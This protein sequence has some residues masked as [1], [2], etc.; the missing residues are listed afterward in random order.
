MELRALKDKD[1]RLLTVAEQT[2]MEELSEAQPRQTF[3]YIN[4]NMLTITLAIIVLLYAV[5]GGLEAAFITDMIQ[6]IFIIILTLMLI[7]FA[8][9][10]INWSL[11]H[12]RLSGNVPGA[13]RNLPEAFFQV[14]GSPNLPQFT[15]YYIAAFA[16]MAFLNTAV[17]ANQLT[18]A[19]SAKDDETA[20]IGFITG[21]FIKRYCGVIWGFIAM[22][23]L[24]LY[25]SQV[26][27]PDYVWGLATRELLPVGLVGLMIACSDGGPD[28]YGGRADADQLV[29]ADQQCL[30]A[31]VS[32]QERQP[33]C[34]GRPYFLPGL[35]RRRCRHCRRARR[36]LRPLH[37][38]A[39]LQL[40]DCRHLLAGHAVAPHHPQSSVDFDHR[41]FPFYA[42]PS[43]P[44]A[45][46][47]RRP[48][49]RIS[50]EADAG[51][52]REKWLYGQAGG[53]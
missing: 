34:I 22:M 12:N 9:A 41:H 26:T 52:F 47:P 36:R 35:H 19:G 7:P 30:Q 24:L 28:V 53:C 2:R 15:W 10:K 4:R 31:D 13:P 40:D 51:L 18:A 8:M 32:G 43:V 38:H 17:Q 1:Y 14:L 23:T 42:G 5:S 3:S 50:R 21:I 20:R 27:D 6:G 48:H 33:L 39:E 11:R 49:E 44:A 25:G 46:D 45:D 29:A 16:V 37:F